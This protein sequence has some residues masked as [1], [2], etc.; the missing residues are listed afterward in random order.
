MS[1]FDFGTNSGL[2]IGKYCI[3]T[4]FALKSR[5]AYL[6]HQMGK[7]SINPGIFNFGANLGLTGGEYFIKIIFDIMWAV[8]NWFYANE[9]LY[10]DKFF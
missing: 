7:I 9:F 4:I 3:K 8:N 1:I 2:T 5:S 10:L 6:K